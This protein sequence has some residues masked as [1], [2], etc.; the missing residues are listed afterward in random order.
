MRVSSIATA[1][2]ARSPRV[3]RGLAVVL[4]LQIAAMLALAA[5]LGTWHD[6]EY[7]L[8]TTSHGV[9][10]AFHRAID[11]ELQAPFYFVALAAL[12]AFSDSV[13]FARAPS[14]LCAVAFTYAMALIA[15]RIAPE[16]DPWV[17]AAL[18][19]LNPF[20]IF[21]A[22]EIR[23]YAL[24]LLLCALAWLAFYDGFFAGD[25]RRARIAF[26]AIAI[27][28]LYTQ[29]FIGFEFVAF[30]I[31]LAALGRWRA[32]RTYLVAGIVLAL[33]F[34]PMLVVLQAQVSGA[35]GTRDARP[36]A[37]GSIFVH[38]AIDFI[39][40]LGYQ[41]VTGAIGHRATTVTVIALLVAIVFGGP[42]MGRRL[43][44][45][46]A[47]AAAVEAIYV[48]LARGLH[49]DLVVPRHFVALF[50]PEL[51]AA[52]ALLVSLGSPRARL[53]RRVVVVMLAVAAVASDATTYR[54]LAKH[55]D[56]KRV[57]A[58]LTA[59]ARPGDTIAIY[60]ADALPGFE[61]Y[62]RGAA[63]V[64]PFPRALPTDRYDVEAMLVH[65]VADAEAS[66]E[67]LPRTGHVWF[68]DYGGCDRFDRLGCNEV[69]TAIA[70]RERVLQ[71]TEFYENTVLRI[72]R[73]APETSGLIESHAYRHVAI[74]PEALR[75]SRAKPDCVVARLAAGP[76]RRR[77]SDALAG[78]ASL[79]RS[80]AASL[81]NA[82]TVASTFEPRY[83][84]CSRQPPR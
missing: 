55:G 42:R 34:V 29:Y 71:R 21:A 57:G 47:M 41:S 14:V 64:V 81:R 62:Y 74:E 26:V 15:R 45:Y 12:R 75:R 68:V 53:A 27:V 13:F 66:L 54:A 8:A 40:P 49:Y 30:A 5:T 67:R 52:F 23:L 63:R 17:P 4:A 39:F 33:A 61:R 16:R 7:S 20:T 32:L 60:E 76:Y 28:S 69:R 50:V 35:L 58:Y 37:F 25:D 6:E 19:A 56:W 77:H 22:L 36:G 44:A 73:R 11:F 48:I 9:V 3:G 43:V 65:S 79:P 24:A 18:V 83:T 10:Y 70:R 31:G 59:A 2:F 84:G 51:A 78:T 72:A 1:S 80:R 38:P 82:A 46:V